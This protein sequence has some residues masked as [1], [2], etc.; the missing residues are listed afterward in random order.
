MVQLVGSKTWIDHD[1]LSFFPLWT[2][3]LAIIKDHPVVRRR[4]IGYADVDH[5]FLVSGFGVPVFVVLPFLRYGWW[6][7][8]G[9]GGVAGNSGLIGGREMEEE[10]SRMYAV[11]HTR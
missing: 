10:Y 11:L 5:V 2:S 3:G 9:L 7:M 6:M 1:H 8:D 4:G